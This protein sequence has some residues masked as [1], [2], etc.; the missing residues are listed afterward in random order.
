MTAIP[1]SDQDDTPRQAGATHTHAGVE[2]AGLW[3]RFRDTGDTQARNA[4]TEFYF[5]I[6]RAN[7][8]NIA[9]IL[10]ES[11]EQNDLSQTGAVAFFEAMNEY[12]PAEHGSF[13][14]F[15]SMAI[16]RAIMEEIRGLIGI[17]WTPPTGDE[18]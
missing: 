11:I 9:D 10:L 18:S 3:R 7:A 13:E 2:V 8:E 4:L 15:G 1:D 5:D 12:D 17:D 16:R 14:E 6:V